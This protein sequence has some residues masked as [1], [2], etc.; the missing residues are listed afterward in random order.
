ML[1]EN[2][3]CAVLTNQKS[4]LK[5]VDDISIE[6]LSLGQIL[7]KV[8]YT[9]VCQSQLMEIGGK[10][11]HDPW[12]PH[13]LGHEAVGQV[14]ST[15]DGVTKVRVGDTVVLTWICGTGLTS[16]V[17]QFI[18]KSLGK[19]NAGLCTTFSNFT[20][21]SENRVVPLPPDFPLN[22]GALL[23]CALPTGAGMVL[24]QIKPKKSDSIVIIGLGGIGFSALI[25]LVSLGVKEIFCVDID[26][27]KLIKAK[28]LGAK[29]VFD[30]SSKKRNEVVTSIKNISQSD[31]V[32]FAI[33]AAG[34]T[35]SIEFAFDCISNEG[36]CFFAS[37]PKYGDKIQIDPFDLIKGKKISGSWGGGSK[38]DE[39]IRELS[40]LLSVKSSELETLVD[41]YFGLGSIN[42]AV[43]DL[44]DRK[45]NRAMIDL[46]NE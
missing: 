27:K 23:G 5:L 19:I 40:R 46:T 1:V 24:N 42:L 3:K 9:G 30:L 25:A 41:R 43:D 33:E 34:S 44:R 11:G 26:K 15:G 37:H 2:I 31:G 32:K 36:H 38:P 35:E 6:K 22:L 18:S 4:Q 7:V 8:H 13:C 16:S 14:V 17:P 39:T 10:R 45:I 29:H 21:V 12:I 20:V 28:S